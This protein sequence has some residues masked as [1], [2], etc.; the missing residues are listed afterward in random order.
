MVKQIT[1]SGMTP[2]RPQTGKPAI[3]VGKNSFQPNVDRQQGKS[4]C[5]LIAVS[6]L[7]ANKKPPDPFS[8]SD[9]YPL[10][11]TPHRMNGFCG[12]FLS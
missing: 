4:F 8:E 9:G 10:M 1:N 2:A 5:P 3:P 6:F 7:K 12:V 11:S